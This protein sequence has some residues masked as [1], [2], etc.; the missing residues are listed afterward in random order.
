MIYSVGNRLG[1]KL[2]GIEK[3]MI[4]RHNLFKN[5]S[6]TSKL[7][8]ASWSPRLHF[9]A[10]LFQIEDDD[11]L[12]LYDVLQDSIN[13]KSIHKDWITHWTKECNYT[14]KFIENTNDIKIYKKSNYRM[15]VH[16]NDSN[17]Q[18]LDYINH[19]DVNQRKIRRDLYDSRGFLSC[20]RTLT[21]NQ[22]VVCE[23]YY[24]PEGT[25]KFQ[26]FFN[27]ELEN[28]QSQLIIYNTDSQLKYFN[29]DQELLAFAIEKLYKNGDI[30]LS[31][32][33]INTAPIFNNTSE[34]I[35][36]LAVLHSTHVKN[37]DMVYESD[38]KNTYKHVFNNLNRYSGIIVSTKQ[39]QLDISARINNEI[40]VHTIPVGYIDEHFTNLKRNNHS[41]NN[42]KIISVARYSP[43]KQLN[44]QIELVSKLI[45]EFPNIQLHLY[46]FGKE[47]EKYKQLI[48]EY[49]LENNVFLRGFRRNLSAEIQD[50]YM[51]LITSNMEGF[52]LGLLETITE[53]IP[54]V[55]YNSKYGPSELI[56]NNE[57]GYLINKNDKD[58]LYNRVRN[59]LLDK[60]L[61]DTFS[62]ECIKHSKAF[63]SKIVMKL[64]EDRFSTINSSYE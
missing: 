49:N 35:P 20:S 31:D 24:T 22:K 11:I 62:Q 18:H 48:T 64:W 42:N 15:Y 26:K 53:G 9:N 6:I 1:N 13:I 58:E 28:S 16:F 54:P 17:Y 33:N 19:F 21:T 10:S 57:N 7:I 23:H 40:P 45:K 5:H 34:T 59:L 44:H 47:E 25:I 43:E 4:N 2:T 39:Q 27:P 12:S 61:R 14:L 32:K 60:T 41:I 63:S 36:V 50:A 30:F 3:A 46:G 8:F 52:N 56:L 37:I 51:S 29:N 38:I 55:G